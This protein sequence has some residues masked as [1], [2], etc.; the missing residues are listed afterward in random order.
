MTD[1]AVGYVTEVDRTLGDP[2]RVLKLSET[3][4]L[5]TMPWGQ[6]A[7]IVPDPRKAE[8][9]QA[10]KYLSGSELEQAE[11]RNIVQR[12]IR[13][14]K[15]AENATAYARYLADVL[16]GKSEERWS[17]PPFA[18]WTGKALR[19]VQLQS[20][21]GPDTIAYLPYDLTGV[22]MDAETQHLAHFLLRQ[23]PAAYGLTG[24]EINA[25]LVG[26]EI[27]HGIDLVAARQIFHDRNLL[28]VIP[29]KNVALASDSS[30][31]ATGITL[32][33]LKGV[34]VPAGGG[35]VP[36]E[37]VISVRQRQLKAADPEW[38]TLSTLR[39]FVVTMIFGR[40]GFDKTSGPITDLP[41]GCTREIAVPEIKQ[42]LTRILTEFASAF[43]ARSSMVIASPAVF[44][45]LG[46]VAHRAT[47]WGR[48]K[49]EADA[50]T[51]DQLME[52]LADVKW[53]RDPTY[54]DGTAGKVTAAGGFSLAGGV[55]DNG[56]KTMAALGDPHSARFRQVRYGEAPT[57]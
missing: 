24:E 13:T 39:S 14:T 1:E 36:L 26:V 16:C 55:K 32:S 53:D 41:D 33:L 52:L 28:G 42:V 54:W 20:P 43:A 3:R 2:V 22:L 48:A 15:K 11:T 49:A 8:N 12:A 30:N 17:T 51:V 21:F 34:R 56:S 25:R 4:F 57:G 40:T 38:M 47:S 19:T 50:L 37:D 35:L 44:A 45:A 46:A 5:A 27:Y 6:L 29:N 9:V 23:A 10:L 18:L 7:R 31:V